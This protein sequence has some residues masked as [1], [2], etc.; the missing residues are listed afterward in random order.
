M[1]GIH[2]L[3]M[4]TPYVLVEDSSVRV[5][6]QYH[7][8]C[9]MLFDDFCLD[10]RLWDVHLLRVYITETAY[11]Q[12]LGIVALRPSFGGGESRDSRV[13]GARGCHNA[14]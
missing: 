14:V 3:S 11:P 13:F 10:G 4:R 6:I 5:L 9:R 1:L 2:M 8:V 7:Q 12:I